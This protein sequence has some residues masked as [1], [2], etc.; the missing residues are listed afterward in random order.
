MCEYHP[1][2][3]CISAVMALAVQH[4]PNA[5]LFGV[6]RIVVHLSLLGGHALLLKS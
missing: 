4:L 5:E 2:E 3:R 6:D 1:G